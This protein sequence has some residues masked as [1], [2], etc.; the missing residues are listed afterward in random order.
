MAEYLTSNSEIAYPIREDAAGLR[1]AGAAP[2]IPL[3]L[4]VDAAF[5]LDPVFGV[6]V[7]S[8]LKRI[9]GTEVEA[10]VSAGPW[11]CR[12]QATAGAA[13]YCM[14]AGSGAV[15]PGSGRLIFGAV[16]LKELLGTMA[17]DQTTSFGSAL[18]FEAS[19]SDPLDMG[20]SSLVLWNNGLPGDLYSVPVPTGLGNEEVPDGAVAGDVLLIAQYNAALTQQVPVL[21]DLLG[22]V[23]SVSPGAGAGKAPC[24]PYGDLSPSNA[25][26]G[27]TSQNGDLVIAGGSEQCY[28]IIPAPSLGVLQ[29]QG[30]CEACCTCDDYKVYLDYLHGLC[31]RVRA[32]KTLLDGGRTNYEAG[33]L[34]YN[35]VIAPQYT[36]PYMAVYGF[37][38]SDWSTGSPNNG[39][40][41]RLRLVIT[42]VN[43]GQTPAKIAAFGISFT[44][45]SA[46]VIYEDLNWTLLNQTGRVTGP[47]GIPAAV[48]EIPVGGRV[49]LSGLIL[50]ALGLW[51]ADKK[52]AGTVT[53]SVMA[54]VDPVILQK[55][56]LV[57]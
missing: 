17:D 47:A 56:F 10:E 39:S 51:N 42:V 35:T 18:P 22:I 9:S 27:M 32:L 29:I 43:G 26:M 57:Q 16:A 24:E 55:S 12:L 34:R 40:P 38:G 21:N 37:R 50:V 14:G 30:K 1:N 25:P 44:D 36:G 11:T 3:G 48:P 53:A 8:S 23:V 41:N 33:V 7:L 5:C 19:T 20:V 28:Q 4:L 49:V 52:W 13:P 15:Y 31:D 46:S 6:P 45:P 2:V 54:G